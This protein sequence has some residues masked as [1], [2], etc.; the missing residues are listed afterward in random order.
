MVWYGGW[1]PSEQNEENKSEQ[2]RQCMDLEHCLHWLHAVAPTHRDELVQAVRFH[3]MVVQV[4]TREPKLVVVADRILV[5]RIQ[6]I[7]WYGG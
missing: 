1:D 4:F 2:V 3:E 7:Y 6:R 5:D